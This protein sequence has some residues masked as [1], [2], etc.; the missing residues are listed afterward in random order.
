MAIKKIRK[1]GDPVLREKSTNIEKIDKGVLTLVEDMVDTLNQRGGVGLSAPQ[2][3]VS[4]NIIIIYFEEKFETYINPVVEA[5]TDE[6]IEEE[7]GCL[8]IYAIQGFKVKRFQKIKVTATNLRGKKVT[9][10]AS[11]LMSRIFQHEID[12]LSGILFIDLLDRKSRR[13]L[14]SEISRTESGKK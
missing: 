12:H 11:D 7:E 5:L 10:T 6:K 4:K 1:I 8:S 3:G 2:I 14:L 13:E 9:I